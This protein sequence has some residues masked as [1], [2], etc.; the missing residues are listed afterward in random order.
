MRLLGNEKEQLS[1]DFDAQNDKKGLKL[2]LVA[3]NPLTGEEVPVY[4]ANYVLSD[5]GSGA[6]F[7]CPAHDERDFEFAEKYSLP[8]K[9]VITLKD[10]K[11]KLPYTE[12]TGI[13]VSSGSYD[14]K[15]VSEARKSI[16]FD[17]QKTEKGNKKVT[18]RLRDWGVSRQRYW[19]CPIPII[20][21]TD[22]G[23]VP[24]PEADLPVILPK[25]V[26]F[27]VQGNP[28]DAHPTWKNVPCPKCG[29]DAVRDTDTLD[30][31]DLHG[32]LCAI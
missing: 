32:T 7:G 13:M 1:S 26:D 27:S 25:D 22:C 24:V 18:Y 3:L 21:C 30:T 20:N 23:A 9:Q 16:L 6:V 4:A 14:G 19:G 31:F 11:V 29:K 2:D 15:K 12:K 17:L 5:Y 8:I 28:L 10:K